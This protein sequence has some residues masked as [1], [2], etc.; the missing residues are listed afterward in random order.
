MKVLLWYLSARTFQVT[1]FSPK[2][3]VVVTGFRDIT[4]CSLV[5]LD[6]RFS[7]A[8]CFHQQGDVKSLTI[9]AVRTSEVSV[10]LNVTIWLS[11]CCFQHQLPPSSDNGGITHL[12][13][14]GTIQHDYTALYP[15]KI[16]SSTILQPREPEISQML[17]FQIHGSIFFGSLVK[18]LKLT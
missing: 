5:E 16:L 12:W 8:Y 7:C 9:E 6:R 13:I 11:I 2:T 4:P 14:V 17:W 1:P 15:L 10:Y 18:H 3:N